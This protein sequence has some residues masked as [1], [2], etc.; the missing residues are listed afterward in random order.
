MR[1]K[2][3]DP[4]FQAKLKEFM[5]EKNAKFIMVTDKSIHITE[6][7]KQIG[8][9]G[10]SADAR[11]VGQFIRPRDAV[12]SIGESKAQVYCGGAGTT[13]SCT[14]N[15][16]TAWIMESMQEWLATESRL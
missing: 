7:A 13:W 6:F 2:R 4:E 10:V 8:A 5:Y 12:R 1:E 9:Q 16:N 3:A 14:G 11:A 15:G